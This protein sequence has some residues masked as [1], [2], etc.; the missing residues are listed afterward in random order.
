M[1]AANSNQIDTVVVAGAGIMGA[2][3]A[4]NF[5][6]AGLAVRVVDVSAEALGNCRNQIAVNLDAFDEFDL[7]AEDKAQI[8]ERIAYMESD[9]LRQRPTAA[10]TS[11]RPC[12]R[13]WT[14]NGSFSPSWMIC[15][16]A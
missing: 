11:S 7:L 9:A 8:A 6:Q 4:L 16:A 10:A 2:G 12:P 14:S 1:T 13:S 5:A 3:I 15:R